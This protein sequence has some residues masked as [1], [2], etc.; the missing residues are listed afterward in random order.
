[1]GPLMN[2][3]PSSITH[4]CVRVIGTPGRPQTL[5]ATQIPDE[6]VDVPK[7]HLFDV[8]ANGGR[9]L[10]HLIHQELVQDGRLSSIVQPHH[11][12]LVFYRAG[13]RDQR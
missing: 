9:C 6:K 11:D 1:M 10:D 5:L 2:N 7:Y 3:D 13:I 12:D 4:L 8:R